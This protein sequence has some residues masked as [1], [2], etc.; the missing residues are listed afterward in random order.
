MH[1]LLVFDLDG[2]L[3]Q[4]GKGMLPEDIEKLLSLE[5]EGYT[6][7]ICSGKPSYYLCGFARQI[8]LANPILV[9]ENGATPLPLEGSHWQTR[10]EYSVDVYYRPFG[11]RYDRLVGKKIT[12]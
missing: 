3:A 7:V 5:K 8:G 4:V 6:I 10:N 1:R 2:T 11:S 12:E 9:G